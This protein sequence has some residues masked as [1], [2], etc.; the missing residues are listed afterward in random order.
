MRSLESLKAAEAEVAV[1]QGGLEEAVRRLDG[2]LAAARQR[3]AGLEGQ[4]RGRDAAVERLNR[5]LEAARAAEF[6]RAA[7]V[8]VAAIRMEKVACPALWW[9]ALAL[10]QGVTRVSATLSVFTRHNEM[11]SSIPRLP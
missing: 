1:R 11:H 8:R 2:Q 6:E 10:V 5:Q 4:L 3:T 7:K 9:P